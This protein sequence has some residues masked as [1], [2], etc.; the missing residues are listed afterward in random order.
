MREL[1]CEIHGYCSECEQA[2]CY[3]AHSEFNAQCQYAFPKDELPLDLSAK[4]P[5]QIVSPR[6]HQSENK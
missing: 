6:M 3:C 1:N 2:R 5:K 4:K